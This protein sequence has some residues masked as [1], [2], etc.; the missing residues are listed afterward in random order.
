MGWSRVDVMCLCRDRY[1]RCLDEIQTECDSGDISY[2]LVDEKCYR[3]DSLLIRRCG[4]NM[5]H[6]ELGYRLL[7]AEQVSLERRI[8]WFLS[9]WRIS[10]DRDDFKSG[11]TSLDQL[12]LLK[13]M[14]TMRQ[15]LTP[16]PNRA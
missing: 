14:E 7:K 6:S 3:V 2:V 8:I 10:G 9:R 1:R 16:S 15:E 5:M 12:A 13:S 11:M 4:K